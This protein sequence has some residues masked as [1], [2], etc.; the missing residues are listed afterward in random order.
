VYSDCTEKITELELQYECGGEIDE[1]PLYPDCWD[2]DQEAFD[3]FM[4]GVNRQRARIQ[5]V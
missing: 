5:S 3:A 2:R 1:P 4:A